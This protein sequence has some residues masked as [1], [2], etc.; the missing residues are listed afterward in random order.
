M[1]KATSHD[2]GSRSK[3]AQLQ[4]EA[5]KTGPPPAQP[6]VAECCAPSAWMRGYS[7]SISKWVMGQ[8]TR[9]HEIFQLCSSVMPATRFSVPNKLKSRA[10][11]HHT[12]LLGNIT[13]DKVLIS[14]FVQSAHYYYTHY[15]LAVKL[16]HRK[17]KPKRFVWYYFPFLP[18]PVETD[19][20]QALCLWFPQ[21]HPVTLVLSS[22]PM[23][24]LILCTLMYSS[25]LYIC[26]VLFC[27]NKTN[28][29]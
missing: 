22:H 4:D 17:K 21:T 20:R 26:C 24:H 15:I 3:E 2:T 8:H 28:F 16:Q 18:S 7:T 9:K 10:L 13:Q 27:W 11:F 1:Q 12:N 29:S 14:L 5:W 23:K 25:L 6:Q 19:E